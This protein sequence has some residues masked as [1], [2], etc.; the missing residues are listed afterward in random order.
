[1]KTFEELR[2]TT[3]Q[4]G[5]TADDDSLDDGPVL[6]GRLCPSALPSG[7][8]ETRPATSGLIDVRAMAMAYR[9]ETAAQA[10]EAAPFLVLAEGTQPVVILETVPPRARERSRLARAWRGAMV[11]ALGG[12][13]Y[14]LVAV[15]AQRTAPPVPHAMSPIPMGPALHIS[16]ASSPPLAPHEPARIGEL[17]EVAELSGDE[18]PLET[19][20][21]ELPTTITE[22]SEPIGQTELSPAERAAPT[23]TTVAPERL[24]IRPSNSEIAN[25]IVDAQDHLERCRD[26]FGTSGLVPIEIEVAPSGVITSVAV[27]LGSSG[28]RACVRDSVRRQRLPASKLGTTAKFPIVVR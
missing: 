2:E 25:A 26:R 17:P 22:V 20:V 27:G 9:N 21:T 14:A 4:D 12:A 8:R 1:M 19:V 7:E 13:A 16:A 23:G 3:L 6:T 5:E 28:F 24:P 10:P 11:F 18:L 15:F